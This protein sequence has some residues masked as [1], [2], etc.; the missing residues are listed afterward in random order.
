MI[1]YPCII[2]WLLLNNYDSTFCHGYT[3]GRNILYN[4]TISPYSGIIPYNKISYNFSTTS[5]VCI[6]PDGW[7]TIITPDSHIRTYCHLM[8]N[9]YILSNMC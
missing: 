8:K 2:Q 7:S 3:I 9:N 6:I 4:N 5:N 1:S